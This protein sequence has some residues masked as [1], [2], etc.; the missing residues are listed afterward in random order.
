CGGARRGMCGV[1]RY[2][3]PRGGLADRAQPQPAAFGGGQAHARWPRARRNGARVDGL[4][5]PAGRRRDLVVER[6]Q[7]AR[8]RRAAAGAAKRRAMTQELERDTDMTPTYVGVVILEA[9]IIM[10]LWFL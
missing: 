5:P 2:G 3:D 4:A 8:G 10:V 6:D 9:A 1:A 7:R